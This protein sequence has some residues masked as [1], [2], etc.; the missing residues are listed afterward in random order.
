MPNRISELEWSLDKP[1][2]PIIRQLP[3]STC[4]MY[5]EIDRSDQGKW[6]PVAAFG[7]IVVVGLL[8]IRL[9]SNP[10]VVVPLNAE[11]L[12]AIIG[13]S[14]MLG[15]LIGSLFGFLR[16]RSTKINLDMLEFSD[17][18]RDLEDFG[19][20]YFEGEF[21]TT[22]LGGHPAYG[23]GWAIVLMFTA[24]AGFAVLFGMDAIGYSLGSYI[25]IIIV[26]VLYPVGFHFAFR[27]SPISSSYVKNPLHYRITKYLS[28]EDV[29]RSILRCETVESIIVR[30]RLGKGQSLLV[31]D[32]IRVY[33]VTSANPPLE[34]EITIENMED[35]GPQFIYHLAEGTPLH[36]EERIDVDG[37]NAFLIIDEVDLDSIIRVRYDVGSIRAKWT[38]GTPK[39]LCSLMHTLLDEVSKFTDISAPFK[40]STDVEFGFQ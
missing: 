4:G 25:E 20:V 29:L 21:E 24:F 32:D 40:D 31:I 27:G 5:E 33:A 11:D 36:K 1:Y 14:P 39:D 37:K 13:F 2:Y 19:K 26:A 34:I 38:L 6:F 23:C 30:F 7:F 15:Y 17:E 22:N 18:V 28:K 35:I 8:S 12:V 9:L 16:K 10:I 3:E